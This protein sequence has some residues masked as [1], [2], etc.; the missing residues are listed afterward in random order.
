[1]ELDWQDIRGRGV[2]G[3]GI[4]EEEALAITALSDADDLSALFDTA[5][6][7]RRAQKGNAINTCGISNAKSGRCPEKCNF[8]SQSAHFKTAAPK[9]TTKSAD[10]IVAEAKEAFD[11]GVREFSIVMA[12]RAIN[13]KADLD[14]LK[15][16]FTRIREET[17]LQTCASLGLMTKEHLAELKAAGMQSMHHN[18]ETARSF[19]DQIVES[20]SYDDE[21]ETIRAAKALGMYVCSGGIFGMGEQWA[22]RVEMALDLRDLDVD[23]VPINFLNPRPG[24]PLADQKDLTPMDGLKIIA[25]YRLVMPTKDIIVCGGRE[26]NLGESQVD[27]FAAGANGVMLGNYLTTAG[28]AVARDLEMLADQGLVVRAPPH[29][30]HPPSVP[31]AVRSAGTDRGDLPP[32]A[33]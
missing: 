10:T 14:I 5:A 21:V 24:T 22:H 26:V 20:H 15:T 4:S 12:G 2:R 13:Q 18:L 33:K 16:A 3:V 8:C 9:Y 29:Q 23:S 25:L 19:H 17:G 7:V 27:I 31:P 30:P 6:F 28:Q 32:S 11:Y 1:M